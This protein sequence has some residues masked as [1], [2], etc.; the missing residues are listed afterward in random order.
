MIFSTSGPQKHPDSDHAGTN[1]SLDAIQCVA[2]NTAVERVDD[3]AA[4]DL[5]TTAD[6]FA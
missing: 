3:L 4:A 1:A 5:L 6:D 2:W